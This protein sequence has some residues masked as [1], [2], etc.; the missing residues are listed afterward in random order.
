MPDS[1]WKSRRHSPRSVALIVIL[2]MVLV[3]VATVIHEVGHVLAALL[4]GQQIK[5]IDIFGEVLLQ[6]S[7][8]PATMVAINF[9]GGLFSALVLGTSYLALIKST[10]GSSLF[11]LGIPLL[12]YC[13]FEVG[14]GLLE[15]LAKVQYT[16]I[17]L[18]YP[19]LA[20]I[21]IFGLVMVG[22]AISLGT[23]YFLTKK[24]LASGSTVPSGDLGSGSR[25]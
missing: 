16:T 9:S 5:S 3:V 20:Y 25:P 2:F 10:R 8:P 1:F 11:W 19:G 6:N 17:N 14:N 12:F 21:V 15:G 13:V 22:F 24:D 18:Y 7:P 23:C 4:L